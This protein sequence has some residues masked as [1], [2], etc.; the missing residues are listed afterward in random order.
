MSCLIFIFSLWRNGRLNNKIK[1]LLK[2]SVRW[3]GLNQLFVYSFIYFFNFIA[4]LGSSNCQR[5]S[6]NNFFQM[7]QGVNPVRKS[8]Q[9]SEAVGYGLKANAENLFHNGQ[10]RAQYSISQTA[11][12][13]KALH[14]LSPGN[15]LRQ[16]LCSGLAAQLT[17]ENLSCY[18]NHD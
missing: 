3:R 6:N 5:L 7:R 10:E 18:R 2:W 4:R 8:A 13:R 1:C 17:T 16:W 9:L 12:T 15:Q 14:Y 11:K